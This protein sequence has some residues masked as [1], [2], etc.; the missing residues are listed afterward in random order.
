MG[1]KCACLSKKQSDQ[2]KKVHSVDK[3]E[4]IESVYVIST[5]S[6]EC[7]SVDRKTSNSDI[8]WITPRVNGKPLQ[9]ELDTGSAV[10]VISK[11]NYTTHV[12]NK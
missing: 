6:T 9:M 11:Q 10:S 5:L 2:K 3:E 1:T 7:N 8:I 4:D 12:G